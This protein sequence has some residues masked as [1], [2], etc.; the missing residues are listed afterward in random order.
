MRKAILF[1]LLGLGALTL[2]GSSTLA[3]SCGDGISES[4]NCAAGHVTF[5]GSGFPATVHIN[6]SRSSDGVVYDDFDYVTTSIT[7][8][9]S[10][11]ET[12]VPAGTYTIKVSSN[13]GTLVQTVTT[14]E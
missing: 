1:S 6:V 5:S 3:V 10:F 13:A 8:N 14:G 4:G 11:T 2:V 9:L 7:G 12:L